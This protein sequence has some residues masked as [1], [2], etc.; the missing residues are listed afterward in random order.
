MRIRRGLSVAFLLAVSTAATAQ[1]IQPLTEASYNRAIS[2][3]GPA[4]EVL[5][6]M[7]AAI[8]TY[9]D[10]AAARHYSDFF[11]DPPPVGGA[12]GKPSS[13]LF[14]YIAGAAPG[15]ASEKLFRFFQDEWPYR[16]QLLSPY[17]D[18]AMRAAD[19]ARRRRSF[20]PEPFN[21]SAPQFVVIR[22]GPNSY[23]D[24]ADSIK[25]MTVKREGKLIEPAK[26]QL[27]PQT[28]GADPE[29]EILTGRFW[30]PIEAFAPGE[31][32]TLVYVGPTR[33][34]EWTFTARELTL[35]Q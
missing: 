28:I 6:P 5:E 27:I 3:T 26:T 32:V 9:D 2:G 13:S 35:L 29:R 24:K 11:P 19:A 21:P 23:F 31:K 20:T 18:L 7:R 22:V 12:K 1:G 16:T 4:C 8:E 25:G 15:A 30:F 33:S 10:E 17:C 34:W 14:P